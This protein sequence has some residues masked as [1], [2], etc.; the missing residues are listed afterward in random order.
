[1]LVPARKRLL[2]ATSPPILLIQLKRFVSKLVEGRMQTSKLDK[3]VHVPLG[4]GPTKH[5][6]TPDET[7][8]RYELYG[9]VG[10]LGPG[11]DVGHYIAY[12][13]T[14]SRQ[15][16]KCDDHDVSEVSDISQA[17]ASCNAY[18]LFFRRL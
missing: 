3:H 11:V 6:A 12:V 7:S 5:T 15:W 8:P 10:H 9:V 16:Y 18:L 2:V 1:M 14:S 13:L 4:L 17:F